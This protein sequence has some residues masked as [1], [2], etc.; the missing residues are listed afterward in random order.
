VSDPESEETHDDA[1]FYDGAIG[2]R[3]DVT[4]G[5][6]ACL[7]IREAG[8]EIAAWTYA[9]IRVADAPPGWRRY[10]SLEARDLARLEVAEGPLADRLIATS[11]NLHRGT[12]TIAT[13]R[14]VL[15]SI[16]AAASILFIVFIGIPYAADRL[17]PL[18]PMWVEKR[19]GEAV[20]GQVGAIFG[21]RLCA[22]PEGRAALDKM[23]G[24]L[25]GVVGLPLPEASI[26]TS[27]IPNAV[28]LPGGKVFVF[29]GLLAKAQNPDELAGV[30]AHELGHVVH[31]DGMRRL[32][33]SGGTSFFIGL[34]FGDVTGS[35]AAL[36]AARQ[37]LEASYSRDAERAADAFAIATMQRLG[38]SPAPL[39]E[40]LVRITGDETD[41]ALSI[42]AS[43]PLTQERLETLRQAAAGPATGPP[44]LSAEEWDKLRGICGRE[45]T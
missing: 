37:L 24:G 14:I 5:F 22:E 29:H 43:H 10:G 44:L 2:R 28:A 13:E 19:I 35:G 40:L 12:L 42:L 6:N 23:L 25:G 27:A 32:I 45:R 17:A 18:I 30:L 33:E 7:S 34:L 36:F 8:A 21:R 4:L 38:R 11:P 41:R 39:G 3:R 9:S 16:A 1:S 31:R 26:V 20:E 15:W